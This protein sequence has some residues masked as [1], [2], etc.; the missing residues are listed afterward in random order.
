MKYHEAPY[1]DFLLE[2]EDPWLLIVDLR[3][4]L[5]RA[6]RYTLGE[7]NQTGLLIDQLLEILPRED[8]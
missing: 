4:A 8:D 5:V 7:K 2:V 6:Q 1:Q 3:M